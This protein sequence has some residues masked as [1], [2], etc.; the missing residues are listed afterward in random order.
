MKLLDEVQRIQAIG[1]SEGA[2]KGWDTRGR[3]RKD[4]EQSVRPGNPDKG[5]EKTVSLDLDGVLAI[6]RKFKDSYTFAPPRPGAAQFLSKL[7]GMGLKIVVSSARDDPRAVKE[8]LDKNGLGKYISEVT[9]K[10]VPASYYV[11]DRAI[12]FSGDF[13]KALDTIKGFKVHWA[14]GD[15]DDPDLHK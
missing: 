6:G 14:N 8:Y 10:K 15:K 2:T 4:V 7:H 12:P 9:N 3:G 1:T 13:D 11:D 5:H